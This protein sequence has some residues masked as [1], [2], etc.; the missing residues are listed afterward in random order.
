MYSHIKRGWDNS[1]GIATTLRAGR[2]GDRIPAGITFSA[3]VQTGSAAH[4]AS[5][6][7][8]TGSFPGIKQP[9]RGADHPPPFKCRGH[10][11]VELY[12]YSPSGPSWPVIGRTLTF[13]RPRTSKQLFV[14][15]RRHVYHRPSPKPY[16]TELVRCSM[17][18]ADYLDLLSDSMTE[19]FC[20]QSSTRPC[21]YVTS[22]P[23][24]LE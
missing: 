21:Y 17:T 5:R 16:R 11:R 10:E 22:L 15:K 12:L 13:L 19:M 24:K 1:V 6:T 20:W 8:S 2:T 3:H 23:H 18:W 14:Y 4:P 9:G 7:M